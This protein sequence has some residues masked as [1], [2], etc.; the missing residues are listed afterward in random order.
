VIKIRLKFGF[1]GRITYEREGEL[2]KED[3]RRRDGGRRE[4]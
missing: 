1:K 2:K 4:R 3:R